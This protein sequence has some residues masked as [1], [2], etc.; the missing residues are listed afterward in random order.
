MFSVFIYMPYY[1]LLECSSLRGTLGKKLLGI[2]VI[3]LSG[4]RISFGQAFARNFFRSVSA[5]LLMAGYLCVL[6]TPKKQALHDYAARTLVIKAKKSG[7]AEFTSRNARKQ[8]PRQQTSAS[9]AQLGQSPIAALQHGRSQQGSP[10]PNAS[11]P[12]SVRRSRAPVGRGVP[13]V[14]HLVVACLVVG[15]VLTSKWSP[16]IDFASH[17]YYPSVVDSLFAAFFYALVGMLI[18]LLVFIPIV[19]V[20]VRSR[21][22]SKVRPVIWALGI[23]L[24]LR[25]VGWQMDFLN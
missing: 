3:N 7:V 9:Q 8:E 20:K 14:E 10:A 6:F 11:S 5:V 21:G 13:G 25:I 19:W 12:A 22:H 18:S 17:E 4:D 23:G 15:H 1:V 16:L 2:S 24:A